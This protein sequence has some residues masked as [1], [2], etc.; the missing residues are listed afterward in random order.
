[1]NTKNCQINTS[2]SKRTD[3]A[4][5]SWYC[6]SELSKIFLLS[7]DKLFKKSIVSVNPC[8]SPWSISKSSKHLLESNLQLSYKTFF[9][10]TWRCAIKG[11]R[12]TH[13]ASVPFTATFFEV[14]PAPVSVSDGEYQSGTCTSLP[15]AL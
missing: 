12:D 15:G 4:V 5:L 6:F 1:M 10:E 8:R 2:Q 7:S 3:A 14:G 11:K 13:N 9:L